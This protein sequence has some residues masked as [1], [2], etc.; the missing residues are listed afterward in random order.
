MK[1]SRSFVSI[2]DEHVVER[3]RRLAET[4]QAMEPTDSELALARSK[5]VAERVARIR[6]HTVAPAMVIAAVVL[7]AS[8]SA[9]A[10]IG[11]VRFAAHM[12]PP[13]GI[14]PPPLSGPV[15]APSSLRTHGAMGGGASGV[16]ATLD[17]PVPPAPDSALAPVQL[18]ATPLPPHRS[19]VAATPYVS[20]T[21][22]A[23][24]TPSVAARP[25]AAPD[26]WLTAAEAMRAGD[27]LGAEVAFGDLARSSDPH[28]RDAA[29]LAR[30]QVWIVEGR[31]VDARRE[32]DDLAATGATPALRDQ[33]VASLKRVR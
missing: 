29:R 28:T 23:P 21:P 4:W 18:R 9:A 20:A 6:Q 14:A 1:G 13:V 25:E 26:G 11:L 3:S 24:A 30:A 19:P 8:A 2:G 16:P 27:Y 7:V 15:T 32:L 17:P 12:P 22:S 31:Y 5:F 33:A 10:R